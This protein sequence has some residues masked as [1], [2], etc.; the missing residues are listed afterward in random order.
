[1]TAATA[2][3]HWP[4]P[5]ANAGAAIWR[6]AR[7]LDDGAAGLQWVLKRNCSITPA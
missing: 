7:A 1:M 2:P 6:F 5:N 3:R 4:A